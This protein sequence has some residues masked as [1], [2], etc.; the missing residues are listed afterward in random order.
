MGILHKNDYQNN[1]QEVE[2]KYSTL[3]ASV[4]LLG[5]LKIMSFIMMPTAIGDLHPK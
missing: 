3:A 4:M 1:Y 5:L 2:N